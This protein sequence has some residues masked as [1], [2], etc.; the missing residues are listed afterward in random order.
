[1]ITEKFDETFGYMFM[2]NVCA[3]NMSYLVKKF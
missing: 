3:N 2:Y 1:M